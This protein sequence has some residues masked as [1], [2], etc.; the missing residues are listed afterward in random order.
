MHDLHSS[1]LKMYLMR[2]LIT[3]WVWIG[4]AGAA[5]S[6][7]PG[8]SWTTLFDGTSL[9]R[10]VHDPDHW[11][12]GS[13][14][15]LQPRRGTGGTSTLRQYGDFILELEFRIPQHGNSGV[16]LRDGRVEV[17]IFDSYGATKLDKHMC[18]AIYYA[19]EPSTNACKPAGE[20]NHYQ[21]TCQGSRIGVVLNG[22]PIIDMDLDR[23][24]EARKNPDGTTN[25]YDTP[26]RDLP[27]FGPIALQNHGEKAQ[28]R[29]IR[30]KPLSP[31]KPRPNAPEPRIVDDWEILFD[32]QNFEQ[33][34][35]DNSWAI[36]DGIMHCLGRA[37]PITT[38]DQFGDFTLEFE[39]NPPPRSVG[40][41]AGGVR[42]GPLWVVLGEMTA[43]AALSEEVCGAVWRCLA[44]QTR[45]SV[46][47]NVWNKCQ[48]TRRG[49]ML[50]VAINGQVVTELDR[51]LWTEARKNPDGA[52]N[53]IGQA[54][55]DLPRESTIGFAAPLRYRNVRIQQHQ[56]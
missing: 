34:N 36:R 32:G 45:P 33:W 4:L 12:I 1:D 9:T 31:P 15:V 3:L 14:G 25:W 11:S 2:L 55:R 23:W 56:N 8:Q 46:Q 30:V 51:S 37:Q 43:E 27:R 19:Q 22:A 50:T 7:E 24:T 54:L 41:A 42:L 20:W 35:V 29:N 47:T 44:P 40:W 53:L 6:G 48:I 5:L 52:A 49:M 39:F 38:K 21:I 18:G 16:F 10:F 26:L 13:D 28:F 17:Q